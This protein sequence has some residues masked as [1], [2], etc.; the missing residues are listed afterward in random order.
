MREEHHITRSPEQTEGLARSLAERLPTRAAIA[1]YGDLGSGKTCFVQGLAFGLGIAA[2][3]TSPTFVIVNEYRGPRA[4]VHIDLYRLESAD[5][6]LDL[7]F[8]EYL[9]GPYV[10]AIEWAERADSLLPPET[11][12]VRMATGADPETRSVTIQWPPEINRAAP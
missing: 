10:T 6:I 1:L 11:I 3:V 9:D 2:P 4:L 5:E 8:Q 7:G 12:R